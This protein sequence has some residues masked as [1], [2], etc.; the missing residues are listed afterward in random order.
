MDLLHVWVF[1]HVSEE[2]F[3]LH[4]TQE[5]LKNVVGSEDVINVKNVH[6]PIIKGFIAFLGDG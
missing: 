6:V 3:L 4:D 2:Y 1:I 5:Q